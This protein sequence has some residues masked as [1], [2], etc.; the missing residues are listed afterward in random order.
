MKS[1][2]LDRKSSATAR[3]PKRSTIV[4]SPAG[5]SAHHSDALRA[6][7]SQELGILQPPRSAQQIAQAPQG[8]QVQQVQ[9]GQRSPQPPGRSPPQ[10]YASP[11]PNRELHPGH[12]DI[13]QHGQI[14]RPSS[15][16]NNTEVKIVDE[17]I[18]NSPAGGLE[19]PSMLSVDNGITLADIP[20]LME[21]AQAREQQRSLPRE[22]SIPCIAELSPLEL[23]IMKHSAVLALHRSP[24]KEH[25][26]LD[27]ILESLE[28]KKGGF[29]NK[30]FKPGNNKNSVKKK[31]EFLSSLFIL[32][33]SQTIAQAF[34]V[35]RSR[36]LWREKASIR[37]S[38][39]HVQI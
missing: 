7:R 9:Q 32:K 11:R 31:G 30:L 25:F 8:Q 38:E 24:L 14:A 13:G 23:A 3:L 17:S 20:H 34:L 26:D 4:E 39:P 18:P 6:Q 21:V 15:A 19:E 10:P 1:V 35:F 5:K 22:S 2:H 27:E 37:F 33:C 29:W 28:V 36:S 16:R 12:I